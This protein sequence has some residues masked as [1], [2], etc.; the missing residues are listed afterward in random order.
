MPP[1]VQNRDLVQY[2]YEKRDERT[3]TTFI[4]YKDAPKGTVPTKEGKIR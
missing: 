2:V 4:V 1:G 3:N